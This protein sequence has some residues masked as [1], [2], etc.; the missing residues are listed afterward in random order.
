[1][2]IRSMVLAFALFTAGAATASAQECDN[3]APGVASE[4]ER[5]DLRARARA[6]PWANRVQIEQRGG[7]HRAAAVQRGASDLIAIAQ[8]GRG[9]TSTVT[10]NGDGN[11]ATI[12]QFGRNNTAAITQSGSS[13]AACVIQ[14]GHSVSTEVVQTGG[15]SAGIIQTPRGTREVPVEICTGARLGRGGAL[16]GVGR[17]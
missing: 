2:R 5:T 4:Q 17:R 14:I 13:N 11:T 1:M 10:Q 15:Q 16:L 7:P 9:H 6:T 8:Q 12:R 3:C